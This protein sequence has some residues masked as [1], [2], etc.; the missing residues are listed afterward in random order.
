MREIHVDRIAEAV[1]KL[2]IEAN[3][4][5]PADVYR[6]L[7]RARE[8]E[9]SPLCREILSD[10]LKNADIAASEQMPVC[11]DTGLAVFFLE[12]GQDVHICGG[13]L[14]DAVNLGV[15]R[16]Y[17]NGYLR[18]SALDDPLLVRKNTGDNTPAV[19]HTRL[20]PGED[21]RITIAPKGGG[22]ENMSALGML[23]PAQGRSGVKEFIV[24]TVSKAGSN[25]CPPVIVGVG[26]G[27]T[28][29]KTTW[30]AKHALLRE[31]GEHHENP[32]IAAFETE[33]LEAI[34]DLGIGA[35]GFGGTVTAL[36]VHIETFPAHLA[37][38]PVAVNMQCHAARHQ[39]IVL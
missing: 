1:E 2:C 23:K 33:V 18:K 27:G 39:T 26:I 14:E 10:I 38:L 29:E 19:I 4:Y 8:T 22:S 32:E 9:Q 17:I 13:A 35:Q 21:L 24:N 6:A 11:Q 37:S 16:G 7:E 30:M 5:L 15:H 34:N 28:I 25:P 31:V 3:Y 20:V 36:A 12:V